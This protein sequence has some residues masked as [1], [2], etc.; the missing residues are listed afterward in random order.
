MEAPWG[1]KKQLKETTRSARR[2]STPCTRQGNN[3]KKIQV[4]PRPCAPEILRQIRVVVYDPQRFVGPRESPY[5]VHADVFV[6][7]ARDGEFEAVLRVPDD[8]LYIFHSVDFSSRSAAHTT[9]KSV[10]R[11]A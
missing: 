6:L 10:L 5:P 2:R 4:L 3:L 7:R 11:L 9:L 1:L 8:S